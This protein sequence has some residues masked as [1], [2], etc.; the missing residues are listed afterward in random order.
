MFKKTVAAIVTSA[1]CLTLLA[2]CG[3]SSQP[4]ASSNP[5]AAQDTGNETAG[6]ETESG[7]AQSGAEPAA[8]ANRGE[9]IELKFIS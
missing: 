9:P 2:G 5:E 4:Q 6:G 1:I 7:K 8:E 3:E